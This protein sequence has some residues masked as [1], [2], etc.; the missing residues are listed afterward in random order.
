M[1]EENIDYRLQKLHSSDIYVMG[2]IKKNQCWDVNGLSVAVMDMLHGMTIYLRKMCNSK[3][4]IPT[5][6]KCF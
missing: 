5:F 2:N 4:H 3:C 1:R 6:H